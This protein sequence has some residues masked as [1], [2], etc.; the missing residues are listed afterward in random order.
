MTIKMDLEVRSRSPSRKRSQYCPLSAKA[1]DLRLCVR[2]AAAKPAPSHHDLERLS[3]Q[4]H[5]GA[6]RYFIQTERRPF[7]LDVHHRVRPPAALFVPPSEEPINN[8]R[9][10]GPSIS[11]STVRPTSVKARS[12]SSRVNKPSSCSSVNCS[13]PAGV[14]TI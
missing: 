12:Y 1:S 6:V 7:A 14:P 11:C 13:I 2:R 10:K 4:W 9:L 8:P 3:R 5:R